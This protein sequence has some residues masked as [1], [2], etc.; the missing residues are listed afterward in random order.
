MK[1]IIVGIL[2]AVSFFSPSPLL[3][4][5]AADA[6]PSPPSSPARLLRGAPVSA[7]AAAAADLFPAGQRGRDLQAG[8]CFQ[9]EC[10]ASPNQ[11]PCGTLGTCDTWSCCLDFETCLG[12][13]HFFCCGDGPSGYEIINPNSFLC[14][15]QFTCCYND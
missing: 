8:A 5:M 2:A 12:L 1:S 15:Y 11:V 9:N 10:N 6:A 7:A 4:A 14:P 3:L 13:G